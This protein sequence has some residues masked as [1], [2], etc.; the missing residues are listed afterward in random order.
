MIKAVIFDIDGTLIDSI[1]FHVKAWQRAF[2]KYGKKVP[3]HEICRQLGKGSDKLMPAFL[4]KNELAQIGDELDRYRGELFKTEY[5]P[6]VKSFPKVRELFER[7]KQDHKRIV[8]AS[9]AK[10]D[11]LKTYKKIARIEDLTESDT[12]SDDADGTK[13]QPDIFEKA[14]DPADLLSGYEKSPLAH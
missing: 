13:P 12:S 11:E 9:S 1:S 10:E 5:L 6:L 14:R 2:E 3:I 7:I 8:L 4:G